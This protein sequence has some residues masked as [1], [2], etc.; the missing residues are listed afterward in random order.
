LPWFQG[1]SHEIFCFEEFLGTGTRKFRKLQGTM[2]GNFLL[3]GIVTLK[4]INLLVTIC[5][6]RFLKRQVSLPGNFFKKHH[7]HEYLCQN[8]NICENIL[9]FKS[10]ALVLL[11]HEKNQSLKIS[12]SCPFKR[13]IIPMVHSPASW[14]DNFYNLH[15]ILRMT[16]YGNNLE[17]LSRA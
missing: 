9:E 11:I 13:V 6:W 17:S 14:T 10:W 1:F 16:N 3:L 5:T 2:P 8:E 7:F 4:L 12:C 15:I